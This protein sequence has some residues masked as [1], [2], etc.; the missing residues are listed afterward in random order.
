MT[1]PKSIHF[2]NY[3]IC[4]LMHIGWRS[5]ILSFSLVFLFVSCEQDAPE[6]IPA[7]SLEDDGSSVYRDTLLD[8]GKWFTLHIHADGLGQNLTH[9]LIRSTGTEGTKVWLD[10]GFNASVLDHRFHSFKGLDSLER[11][12]VIVRN[13][14]SDRASIQFN[15]VLGNILFGP[16]TYIPGIQLTA[17]T[18]PDTLSFF[19]IDNA[20]AYSPSLA[21]MK[22]DS[23]DLVFYYGPDLHTMASPG[24]NVED[25]IFPSSISVDQWTTRHTARFKETG[26]S[27]Q[28]VTGIL[29]DSLLLSAY[30][31]GEGKRKVK[32][33]SAGDVVC[34][35][36]WDGRLGLIAITSLS[37]QT[38]AEITF[39][40]WIQK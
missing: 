36:N 19:G 15:I 30:G 2:L 37:G 20:R 10:S 12:E 25:G 26:L 16:I 21:F 1:G 18:H 6:H 22:Q 31:S 38:D 33:L 4:K 17:Q 27:L 24:A 9:L 34:F 11:W 14:N 29:N 5:L 7:L 23:A 13:R 40:L 3:P 28:D 39:D 8:A 35:S 32:T